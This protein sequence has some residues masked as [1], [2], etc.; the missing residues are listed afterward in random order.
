MHGAHAG[1]SIYATKPFQ[2][3]SNAFNSWKAIE[4][5]KEREWSH[6][7]DYVRGHCMAKLSAKQSLENIAKL[8]TNK[9]YLET[10][11]FK[12]GLFLVSHRNKICEPFANVMLSG[13]RTHLLWEN[14]I[15]SAGKTATS[16]SLAAAL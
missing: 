3:R 15:G 6:V 11:Y 9:I 8:R 12:R 10:Q 1:P 4:I 7:K 5:V 2:R 14:T 16:N 13:S